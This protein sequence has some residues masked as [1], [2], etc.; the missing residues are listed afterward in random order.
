M[1][2]AEGI[3]TQATSAFL[4]LQ[5]LTDIAISAVLPDYLHLTPSM[6]GDL[7]V[8]AKVISVALIR[9]CAVFLSFPASAREWALVMYLQRCCGVCAPGSALQGKTSSLD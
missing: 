7:G 3:R 6:L 2:G 8:V 5:L 1:G 4:A 9:S